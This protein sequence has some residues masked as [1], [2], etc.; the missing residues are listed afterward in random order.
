[1]SARRRRGDEEDLS[2]GED[3]ETL[4]EGATV[5]DDG[6]E[7]AGLVQSE[8][9]EGS[10]D[11][12]ESSEESEGEN[13]KE[14][15]DDEDVTP[16]DNDND[17]QT[18]NDDK[19]KQDQIQLIDQIEQIKIEDKTEAKKEENEKNENLENEISSVDS[20]EGININNEEEDD[21]DEEGNDDDDED[22]SDKAN[23]DEDERHPA[24]IPRKGLFFLHDDRI[25]M[26]Y[27]EG[28]SGAKMD[29]EASPE[30]TIEVV[31]DG[32][33][34]S[35]SEEENIHGEIVEESESLEH[36]NHGIIEEMDQEAERAMRAARK[37]ERMVDK[38]SHDKYDDDLQLPRTQ[39]E[40]VDR[41]GFDIRSLNPDEVDFSTPWN[42]GN[43]HLSPN[44]MDTLS[45][46]TQQQ[47]GTIKEP[48]NI[49]KGDRRDRGTKRDTR[50]QTGS[51]NRRIG[52]ARIERQNGLGPR[53]NDKGGPV[54]DRNRSNKDNNRGNNGGRLNNE[55]FPELVITK[56]N[57][58]QNQRGKNNEIGINN[59]NK[60]Q[61]TGRINKNDQRN[62]RKGRESSPMDRD[63]KEMRSAKGR[64]NKLD[65]KLRKDN[66]DNFKK[67]NFKKIYIYGHICIYINVF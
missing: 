40:L 53:G 67:R 3:K 14:D 18:A 29:L 66:R 9:E 63:M 22:N 17:K 12:A 45:N 20:Q 55:D 7:K 61:N 49:Q 50:N 41:Y 65:P 62:I 4:E 60:G 23:E 42:Q 16:G 28:Q 5:S 26:D 2:E 15:D 56:K 47:R 35:G 13:S 11:S 48:I 59:K 25:D 43:E 52:S 58:I 34:G 27:P 30:A 57:D 6:S 24:Y 44:E 19:T 51:G 10:E 64:P 21:D 54:K 46:R 33:G 39:Q 38:W 32:K 8:S 37:A 36:P 1:M 31:G